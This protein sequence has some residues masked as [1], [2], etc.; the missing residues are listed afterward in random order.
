MVKALDYESRDSR[1][2]S[3]C[4][5]NFLFFVL[6]LPFF[7]VS[8]YFMFFFIVLWCIYIPARGS[9]VLSIH[10]L[11]GQLWLETFTNRTVQPRVPNH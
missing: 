4:G 11:I 5:R 2:D 9:D 1:F 7:L 8:L 3:W 6:F 10:L